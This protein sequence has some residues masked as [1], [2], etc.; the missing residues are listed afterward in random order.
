MRMC[1]RAPRRPSRPPAPARSSG[2]PRTPRSRRRTGGEVAH[3]HVGEGDQRQQR[4]SRGRS[5]S[6]R[7]RAARAPVRRPHDYPPRRLAPARARRRGHGTPWCRTAAA[8]FGRALI[9]PNLRP[10]VTTAALAVAYR[11]R[12]LAAVP[13]G[14]GLRAAD[15]AVPDRQPA[16]RRDRPR[17]GR[18]RGRAQAVP[19][20][21]HH[22]QRC[23]RDRPAQDL[24]DA[25]G[26]A[27]RRPAAAGARRGHRP[28]VDL[29]DREACSSS[30]S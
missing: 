21:R 22:Q 26:H 24:Q 20:R 14:R 27:A 17:Q 11:E 1:G 28:D 30:A 15:V 7:W 23:R 12:I 10:P 13:A 8:Q 6:L 29:F 5:A 9:M 4:P 2:R 18:R 19:G 3:Q 16:A 25:G